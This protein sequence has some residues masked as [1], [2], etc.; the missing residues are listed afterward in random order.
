MDLSNPI[1][2]EMDEDEYIDAAQAVVDGM[3]TLIAMQQQQLQ[4]LAM[5]AQQMTRPKRIVRDSSGRALGVET[6]QGD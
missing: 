6:V 2:G 5:L 3:N 4:L 1:P